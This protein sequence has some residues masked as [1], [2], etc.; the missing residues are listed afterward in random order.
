MIM[1]GVSGTRLVPGLRVHRAGWLLWWD[2]RRAVA[3]T[4][5]VLE[6]FLTRTPSAVAIA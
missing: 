4:L 1:A 2:R 3:L 5:Y 6:S